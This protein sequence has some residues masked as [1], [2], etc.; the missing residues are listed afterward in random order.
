MDANEC[1]AAL[2]K[3]IA[4]KISP[5]GPKF[6]LA[7]GVRVCVRTMIRLRQWNEV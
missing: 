5:Q 1:S 3:R 6:V 7:Q 2:L 4:I